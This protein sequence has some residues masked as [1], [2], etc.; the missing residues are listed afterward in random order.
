[1]NHQIEPLTFNRELGNDCGSCNSCRITN[2]VLLI[3]RVAFF[4][5]AAASKNNVEIK[6]HRRSIEIMQANIDWVQVDTLYRLD[7]RGALVNPEAP[8]GESEGLELVAISRILIGGRF[9]RNTN[10]SQF[11]KF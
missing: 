6:S 3:C 1:M 9:V 5:I 4:R 2:Y 8:E 10:D 7:A 11:L